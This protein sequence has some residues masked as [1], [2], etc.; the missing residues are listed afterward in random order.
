[1]ESDSRTLTREG[2]EYV[3]D[4]LFIDVR[5]PACDKLLMKV[6]RDFFGIAKPW[7]RHCKK[8]QV[9]SLAVILK[10]IGPDSAILKPARRASAQ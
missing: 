8:E 4:F 7:C 6:S 9:V 5:C 2:E 1:M 3:T 10:Q